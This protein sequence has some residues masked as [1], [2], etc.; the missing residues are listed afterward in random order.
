MEEFEKRNKLRL[1]QPWLEAR[2]REDNNTDPMC[3]SALA[4]IYIETNY[5]PD[6]F[7][8]SNTYYDTLTVGKYCEKRDTKRAVACYR[9]GKNDKELI[10]VTNKN[11]LFKEQAKYLVER[12][13]L[14]LWEQVLSTDNPH[15]RQLIDQVVSTAL[16]NSKDPED[17][18]TTV[19]VLFLIFF[20]YV[21]VFCF[22]FVIC[23][24]YYLF[25][26][27]FVFFLIYFFLLFVYVGIH[28][29]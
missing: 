1:L 13:E 14:G 23:F 2:V 7:L 18:S 6:E 12:K 24:F 8:Q 3:H 11:S 22:F 17:V 27:Y 16:P 28:G 20:C 10:D 19:K 21:F 26:C 9:K 29:C 25:F 4:K 5:H 15:R